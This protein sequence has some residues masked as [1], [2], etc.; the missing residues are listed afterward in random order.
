MKKLSLSILL[1]ALFA[2]PA[3]SPVSA[4][5]SSN[6]NVFINGIQQQYSPAPILKNGRTLV[7]LRGIFEGLKAEVSWD[8]STQSVTAKKGST[9]VTL[10]IGSRYADKDG[11]TIV[12]DEKPELLDGR[13]MVPVRFVSEALGSNVNWDDSSQ[14]VFI[15]AETA[16]TQNVKSSEQDLTY[17]QALDTALK[18]SISL[19]NAKAD[20]DR[21][22]K[23]R[24]NAADNLNNYTPTGVGSGTSDAAER[25]SFLG[26]T[27]ANISLEMSK[28]QYEMAKDGLAYSVKKAYYEILQNEENLDLA[29]LSLNNSNLQLQLINA[30]YQYGQA[31]QFDV[32][33][34]QGAYDSA[35]GKLASAQKALDDSYQ[36]FNNLLGLSGDTR[37]QPVD[38]PKFALLDKIDL[39][40]YV[41]G[42]ISDNPAIWL[43][44]QQTKLAQLGVS[45]YNFNSGSS[46][47]YDVKQ[48]DAQKAE[49]T[50]SD[51][52][53]QLDKSLRS[54][55]YSIRQL[56]DQY[57]ILK[58]SLD[59]AMKGLKITQAK[60]DA[61]MA[62][63]ADLTSTQ[64]NVDQ[65][66][67]QLFDLTVQHALLVDAFNKPWAASGTGAAN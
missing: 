12:L 43:K 62:I 34:A 42:M 22:D 10:Q 55:Y 2:L 38:Q 36:K 25:S 49:N 30:K 7:P 8:G 58:S 24:D 11:V 29:K 31:S 21:S 19:K 63:K 16:T 56:E 35:S 9:V 3:V 57:N 50:L 46:D 59:T 28:K 27:S 60:Y 13:T 20:I 32:T 39:D 37:Y 23:V 51:S 45:L 47:S 52:K 41:L 48:I 67:K 33:Q 40:S 66:K 15:T 4:A 17:Q 18:N 26:L 61:G 64:L 65:L 54:T 14:S 53:D 1:S 44:E 5:I 6:I